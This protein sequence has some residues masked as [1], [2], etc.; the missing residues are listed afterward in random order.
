M[1]AQ[2]SPMRVH[3][4]KPA[5]CKGAVLDGREASLGAPSERMTHEA[6]QAMADAM[7][8]APQE[9]RHLC[10]RVS[11]YVYKDVHIHKNM[12]THTRTLLQIN[13]RICTCGFI[14]DNRHCHACVHACAHVDVG[15]CVYIHTVV[16][17]F[18]FSMLCVQHPEKATL[19]DAGR[20][21]EARRRM[22][23]TPESR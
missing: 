6:F 12:H 9:S 10:T 18:A 4:V 15:A 21:R 7:A 1:S 22:Q 5:P 23:R 16:F 8:A 3:R 14:Y 20:L 19:I 13:K 11:V 17:V 2:S